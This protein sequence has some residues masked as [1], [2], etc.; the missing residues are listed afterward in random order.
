MPIQL[1]GLSGSLRRESF[2]SALLRTVAE[3]LPEGAELTLYD[4]SAVPLYDA[5]APPSPAVEGLRAAITAAH[6]LIIAT[7]EYNYSVPGVLKNALDHASRPAYKSPLRDKPTGVLS[8]S[9]GVVGGA[10]AQAHLKTVLL[11]M[12]APVFPWP[13]VLLGQAPQRFRDGRLVDG[14]S[15]AVVDAWLAAFV[16][17][18]ERQVR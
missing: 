10:R 3:R 11:G 16:P 9:V 6:A 1:L 17:W 7:P 2:N 13:E 18:V 14:D 8:A 15:L 12:A 5:D 4:Y